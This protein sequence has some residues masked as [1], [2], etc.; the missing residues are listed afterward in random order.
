MATSTISA[1]LNK[2]LEII[3]DYK[4]SGDTTSLEQTSP[5]E[6][7]TMLEDIVTL[8]KSY[9][10]IAKNIAQDNEISSAE[11]QMKGLPTEHNLTLQDIQKKVDQEISQKYA[12]I[13]AKAFDSK[14]DK[15]QAEVVIDSILGKYPTLTEDE[16]RI[17]KEQLLDF[18]V[19]TKYINDDDI[20]EIQV[21]DFNDIVIIKGGKS[22]KVSEQFSS[23]QD[24]QDFADKL[25]NKA[26]KIQNNIPGLSKSNPFTRIRLG[27]YR[28]SIMGGGIAGRPEVLQNTLDETQRKFKPINICIRKQK[29]TPITTEQMLQWRSVSEFQ[30]ALLEACIG[31]GVS[32]MGFGVTGSGKTAMIRAIVVKCLPPDLRVITVAETDEMQLRILDEEEYI[33][34]ET[35]KKIKNPN[36]L[37]PKL[38]VLQWE[39]PSKDVQIL[40]RD[41]FTGSVNASLTFTP[42]CIIFQETKAGEIKDLIEEAISGHQV[43]TTIHVR[44]PEQ[45]PMR[46][47]LMYQ[48]SGTNISDDKILAQV[49][50]AF[51]LLV[52]FKRYRDG[53]RKIASISEITGFIPNTDTPIIRP[54]SKYNV[55]RNYIDPETGKRVVEGEFIAVCD[56]L[57]DDGQLKKIMIDNFLTE[58]EITN[59]INLYQKELDQSEL[60]L[61]TEHMKRSTA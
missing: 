36:Y 54:L 26:S 6:V 32:V 2:A 35:G 31:H 18:G 44:N 5:S 21:N 19:L 27:E 58:D 43:I 11:T 15:K 48:Q 14:Q 45:V 46:I 25:V 38:N 8:A 33:L 53:T 34:D 13:M 20:E 3:K 12:N 40:G 29:S 60:D 47:L 41:G 10:D 50:S 61:Y 9:Q 16:K 57:G 59:L 28:I 52:E 23:P 24:L 1:S 4:Y 56:P 49:P 7:A 51:P 30:L 37:K 17:I 22:L 42:E 39:I 55:K